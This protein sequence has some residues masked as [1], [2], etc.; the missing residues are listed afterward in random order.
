[1][2]I[3]HVD[4]YENNLRSEKNLLIWLLFL[5]YKFMSQ[6]TAAIVQHNDRQFDCRRLIRKSLHRNY[7]NFVIEFDISMLISAYKHNATSC[8]RI[9]VPFSYQNNNNDRFLLV[10]LKSDWI[11]NRERERGRKRGI[12]LDMLIY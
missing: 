9:C 3:R 2:C 6:H 7:G 1:M 8:C 4:R 5:V 11:N 10:F 12:L